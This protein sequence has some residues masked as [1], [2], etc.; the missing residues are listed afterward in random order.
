MPGRDPTF[1]PGPSAPGRPGHRR[2]VLDAEPAPGRGAARRA[3]RVDPRRL[4]RRCRPAAA[5]RRRQAVRGPDRLGSGAGG[6]AQPDLPPGGALDDHHRRPRDQPRAAAPPTSPRRSRTTTSSSSTG[7]S[8]ERVLETVVEVVAE[9]A[10]KRFGV[11]P[12]RDVQV[13][14]PMYKGA[15]G[16]DALNERLQARLNPDGKRG[17]ERALPDRGP[18]DPDPQLARA[19]ADERLDRLPALRR[20][21]GGGDR[22]RHRRGRLAGHPLRGDRDAAPRL[23]DLRPQ[24]AGLRGAGRG[25]RLPPLPRP[26]ADPTPPLHRDHPRPQQLRAGRRLG[27]AGRWRCAATTAAAGTRGWRSGCADE[28]AARS[29]DRAC[30]RGAGRAPVLAGDSGACPLA[31]RP[32]PLRRSPLPPPPPRRAHPLRPLGLRPGLTQ[33]PALR[34]RGAAG[35]ALRRRAEAPPRDAELA[36][37]PRPAGTGRANRRLRA[38]P[39]AERHRLAAAAARRGGRRFQPGSRRWGAG[40]PRRCAGTSPR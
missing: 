25:R 15:V 10:P 36:G 20:P 12:I 39:G 9:R 6:A 1:K 32:A 8:P 7:P 37:G 23:R 17:A 19:G 16:I 24:V 35:E 5:D 2:R 13:L 27:G 18:A 33:L 28:V 29:V 38:G 30:L 26:D 31:R 3:G 22:R 4:R 21:R 40:C 11:D 34:D 14:A